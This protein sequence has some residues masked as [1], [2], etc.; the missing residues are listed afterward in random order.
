MKR[1]FVL[2]LMT[3]CVHL[4]RGQFSGQ[5]SGTAEDPFLVSTA[6]NVWEIRNFQGKEKKFKLINDINLS[7]LIADTDGDAGWSPIPNFCGELDGNGYTISGLF[8]NRPYTDNI[9]FFG[10]LGYGAYVH[11]LTLV[12]SGDIVGQN[13]VGGLCGNC[14]QTY[15]SYPKGRRRIECC[16]IKVK[17]IRGADNKNGASAVGG[18]CGFLS[19]YLSIDNNKTILQESFVSQCVIDASQIYGSGLIGAGSLNRIENNRVR[20]NIISGSYVGGIVGSDAGSEI[21]NNLFE[22]TKIISSKEGGGIFYSVGRYTYDY[23]G[24]VRSNAVICDSIITAYF[25]GKIGR[26]GAYIDS[27]VSVSSPTD[28]KAN[29]AYSKIVLK[30]DGDCYLATDDVLNGYGVGN[31]LLKSASMYEGMGWDMENVWTIEEGN[32]YPRLRWE[33]ENELNKSPLSIT[34]NNMEVEEN[35]ILTFDAEKV[36][37]NIGGGITYTYYQ[38]VPDEPVISNY[39]SSVQPVTVT[40]SSEDY[41]H[42]KWA[43]IDGKNADMMDVSETRSCQLGKG[44]SIP[45]KLHAVFADQNF[46]SYTATVKVSC[47]NFTRTFQIRFLYENP[48]WPICP[49]PDINYV[50]GTLAFSCG[51]EGKPEYHVSITNPDANT[52]I[53][54][55]ELKLDRIYNIEVYATAEGYLASETAK[56][57][58]CWID[59]KII[60]K[61]DNSIKE[62][63]LPIQIR[64]NNGRITIAGIAKNTFVSAYS[65]SGTLLDSTTSQAEMVTLNLPNSADVFILKIGDKSIK[66]TF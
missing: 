26:I 51:A 59:S 25:N 29:K 56:L 18:L 3:L 2:C 40:I 43:G 7:E 45:L 36:T 1:V 65:L 39:S 27:S 54:D 33:V 47:N 9:G 21:Y 10:V 35:T 6:L 37:T 50:D 14:D 5:G 22:G 64:K 49:T 38:C 58:L 53:V 46:G 31:I 12:Y 19:S 52:Y 32:S 13:Y 57:V 16:K 4:V 61:D 11:H 23:K 28:Q 60:D 17:T 15:Q 48:D 63:C 42:L 62:E 24:Y 8:I 41:S 66:I 20:A 55:N 34:N 44:E 30:K